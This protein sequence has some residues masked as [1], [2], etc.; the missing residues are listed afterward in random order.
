MSSINNNNNNKNDDCNECPICLD[1]LDKSMRV[2][3][4]CE[5]EFHLACMQLSAQAGTAPQCPLC[6]GSIDNARQLARDNRSM[7]ANIAD[8]PLST[9]PNDPVDGSALKSATAHAQSSRDAVLEAQFHVERAELVGSESADVHGMLTIKAVADGLHQNP[10]D[11]VVVVDVSGSMSGEKMT[12]LHITLKHIISELKASDRISIVEFNSA[13]TVL[14]N[15]VRATADNKQLLMALVDKLHASGG[16]T[17][18]AG[19]RAAVDVLNGRAA[20]DVNPVTS[21]LLLTDGQDARALT[22][23]DCIMRAAPKRTTVHTYGFGNDHDATVMSGVAKRGNGTFAFIETLRSVGFAFAATLGGL[24]TTCA[25]D[26]EVQMGAI[27]AGA[28][29]AGVHTKFEATVAENARTATVKLPDMFVGEKRDIVFAVKVPKA[30]AGEVTTALVRGAVTFATPHDEVRRTIDVAELAVGRPATSSGAAT[31]NLAVNAQRQRVLA[32]EALERAATLAQQGDLSSARECLQGAIA[33]IKQS[34][35]ASEPLCADLVRDLEASLAR[36][37]D[38]TSV[39]A[40]GLAQMRS[41]INS[42]VQQRAVVSNFGA[43]QQH[44]YGFNA[45]QQCQMSS[46]AA[47]PIH[48]TPSPTDSCQPDHGNLPYGV[49]SSSSIDE[50]K[51]LRIATNCGYIPL[52]Y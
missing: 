15:F 39:Q 5:H 27:A 6:R 30:E 46:Y 21:I 34:A 25:V 52:P 51:S 14:C 44:A 35:A 41:Q 8:R 43:P 22:S 1:P 50:Y 18:S 9:R 20:D 40:G 23:I 48:T 33:S 45:A 17:I 38:K 28:D 37:V 49:I 19:L 32:A 36:L 16:T 24:N 2:K 47:L 7:V 12:L 42:H 4:P 11:V 13:A 3:T 31:I 10:V 26:I 29:I